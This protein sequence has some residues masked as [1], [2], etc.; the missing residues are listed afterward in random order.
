[1]LINLTTDTD[2]ISQVEIS[3]AY[4]LHLKQQN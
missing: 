4:F 2:G 1:M 3:D